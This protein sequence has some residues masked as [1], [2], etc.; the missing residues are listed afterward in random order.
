MGDALEAVERGR[1]RKE[2]ELGGGGDA[3]LFIRDEVA[4]AQPVLEFL[5]GAARLAG[6]NAQLAVRLI[7]SPAVKVLFR[8]GRRR[9][10][11]AGGECHGW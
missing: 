10:C 4:V 1:S 7:D 6:S 8:G 3:M 9:S 5:R 11:G 2:A